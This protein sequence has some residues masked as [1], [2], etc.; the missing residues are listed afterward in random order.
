MPIGN[1]VLEQSTPKTC[2]PPQQVLPYQMED[3][4][5]DDPTW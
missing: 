4:E 3:G 2:V 1:Y 5:E